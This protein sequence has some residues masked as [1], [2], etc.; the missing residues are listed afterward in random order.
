MQLMLATLA[1]CLGA[2]PDG[3]DTVVVCPRTFCAALEP[4]IEHRRQQGY[5]PVWVANTL[6]AEGIR[7]AIRRA[8]RSGPL[9]YVLLVGD[10]E[11]AASR[12]SEV[13]AR[14]VPTH[15]TQAKVN[16]RWGSEPE[17][18]TDNWYADLDDDQ[19]P[20]VAIG[21]IPADSPAELALIVRKILNHEDAAQHG[22]WQRQI[23][24]VAGV[25]S[26]GTLTDAV[27]EMATKKFLTDGI[28][29]SYQT[30]MTYANWQSPYCPDPRLFQ[31][32]TIEQLNAGALLWVYIGHGQ[33]RFLDC[34]PVPGGAFPILSVKETR[35]LQCAGG[36]PIAVLLACSTGAFDQP[37]DCLAE[38]LLKTPGGPVAVLCGSRV[39]M[40]YGMA[41]FG[42]ALMHECFRQRRS[43]L[44]EAF[45]QAQR[46]LASADVTSENRQLLDA[47]AAAFSPSADLLAEERREHVAMFNLLGD[48]LL[49]LPL[50]QEVSVETATEVVAGETLKIAGRCP[51]SGRGVIELA[52]R[53][54]RT[55]SVLPARS[56]FYPTDAFLRSFDAVYAQANDGVWSAR[57]FVATGGE[58]QAELAV[59][60]ECRGPCHVRAF[61]EGQ[62]DVAAGAAPV[63]VRRPPED[64]NVA[65]RPRDR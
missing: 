41:A 7:D 34:V 2:T 22:A 19:I 31:A 37:T 3:P 61:V 46:R 63:F 1:V 35:Q 54:D 47:I 29:A 5:R 30:T 25:G 57:S 39:T 38:E 15:L 58:F 50:P 24:V 16:V 27:V 36:A 48:P 51:L 8:A 42:E 44:G 23:Q 43:T 21:R 20:D 9:R 33:R 55:K 52:C 28:P 64:L 65:A 62:Q 45:L 32:V 56:R 26:L 4:W 17:I 12:D 10:A 13:R 60:P 40:P 11:P 6:P 59:P 18:A 49:R 53:R 14:C